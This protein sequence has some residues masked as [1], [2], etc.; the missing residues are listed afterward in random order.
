MV[1]TTVKSKIRKLP[2][3]GNGENGHSDSVNWLKN[4]A[5]SDKTSCYQLLNSS[6]EGLD[7]DTA[8]ERL[9]D[10]GANEISHEKAPAWYIQF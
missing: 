4:I 9:K 3:Q 6:E 8:E 10:Y 7:E 1:S 5:A 2:F